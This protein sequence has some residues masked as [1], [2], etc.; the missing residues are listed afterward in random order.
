MKKGKI[1]VIEGNDCSGKETQSKLLV[2]RLK[3]EG[4][5]AE[6]MSFPRYDTPTG[7]IVGECYLGKAL[8]Y[9][10]GS[11][12]KNPTSLDPK[13]ATL[14]YAADRRAAR[15]DII[16]KIQDND[17]L[18]LDRY[19][20]SNMAH[21]GGKLEKKEE[22]V[23]MAKWISKL[24]YELL[25][26]PRPDLVIFL[27]MPYEIALNLKRRRDKNLKCRDLDS[28]EEDVPYLRKIEKCYMELAEE[29]GWEKIECGKER[30][31][32]DRKEINENIFNLIKKRFLKL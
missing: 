27:H 23:S 10:G 24:E 7:Q 9:N 25:E 13:I 31:P 6:I 29:F 28:H 11:W 18:I 3:K 19:V 17:F 2:K 16:K 21:Q 14:Y 15:E 26:L 20:E 30:E 8:K 4:L 5:K 32:F 12:F 22:R 1:I